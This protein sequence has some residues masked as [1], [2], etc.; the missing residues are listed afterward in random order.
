MEF[1]KSDIGSPAKTLYAGPGGLTDILPP[2]PKVE[3]EENLD[4]FGDKVF[5]KEAAAKKAPADMRSPQA[6]LEKL[7]GTPNKKE[8]KAEPVPPVPDKVELTGKLEEK[9]TLT[10][11]ELLWEIVPPLAEKIIKEEI[12][13]IKSELSNSGL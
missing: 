8:A 11:K 7:T 13:K 2:A 10:I 1:D 4:F 12:D 9:L 5:E 3:K 6:E